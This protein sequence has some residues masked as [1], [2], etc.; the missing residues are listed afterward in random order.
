MR[1]TRLRETNSEDRIGVVDQPGMCSSLNSIGTVTGLR[2]GPWANVVPSALR[3]TLS[4]FVSALP[5]MW[6]RQRNGWV[7]G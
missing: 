6:S 3:L 4:D 1:E 5:P 2:V 7:R